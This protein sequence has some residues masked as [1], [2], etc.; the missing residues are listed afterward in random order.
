MA[1]T[2]IKT[3][4]SLNT[5]KFQR[6]L[7]N[8]QK[9]LSRFTKDGISNI[10]RLGAAFAGISAVKRMVGLGASAEETAD[11]FKSVFGPAVDEMNAKV[12]KL[13]ETIPATT[14]EIQDAAA[15]FGLMA[16]SFGLNS[17][18]AEGF[19][20]NMVKIA[21][22]LASFHDI[23][24]EVAFD[25][26]RA[27]IAGSSEPLQA[28]G[29][30]IR[31]AA[32]KQEALNL[33]IWNGV[34]VLS[35]SQ[36][37]MAVQS[38][39]ISQM[40]AASGNAALTINST[41]NQMKFL[42][43]GMKEA[44]TTIGSAI[45]PVIQDFADGLRIIGVGI[46]KLKGN[47]GGTKEMARDWNKMARAN[48][49][50]RGLLE[51]N[52]KLVKDFSTFGAKSVKDTEAIARNEALIAERAAELEASYNALND[53][54]KS[55]LDSTGEIADDSSNIVAANKALEDSMKAQVKLQGEFAATE[56][57]RTES[58]LK[59]EGAK[60]RISELKLSLL[61]AEVSQSDTLI[62]QAQ[63]ALD[64]EESIQS[65]MKSTN[66]SRAEA[67]KLAKDLAAA[68]G[69]A[70]ANKSGIVTGRE[71]RAKESADRKAASEAR[72]AK[73]R[74]VA[75][76]AGAGE[77]QR[78]SDRDKRFDAREASAGLELAGNDTTAGRKPLVEEAAKQTKALESIEREIKKNP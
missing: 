9:S 57:I 48:L 54:Q 44:G 35:T 45:L 20:I 58:A 67:I 18:A 77:R 49:A 23:A 22:D 50:T 36:K 43:R 70:D 66:I 31:E 42:V 1:K 12:E 3:E 32:L 5:T 40:G 60:K 56:K 37:A 55:V 8:S 75:H 64:L 47:G 27:G 26:L 46:D 65:I 16:Q 52:V 51:S 4:I 63:K 69:G 25:K 34:G 21:G 38:A 74:E 30:D 6:G 33:G 10:V 72:R 68:E 15:V 17:K 13:K 24:P 71:Q 78:S 2:E 73:T 53:S 29:I 28:L 7:A 11:K 59:S 14:K 39:V 61:R 62:N 76:E 41:A 19:S